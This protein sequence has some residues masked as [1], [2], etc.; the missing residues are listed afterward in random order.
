MDMNAALIER[1]RQ[2]THPQDWRFEPVDG[3][4]LLM[5]HPGAQAGDIHATDG[6][7]GYVLR[8]INGRAHEVWSSDDTLPNIAE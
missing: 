3:N 1:A 2:T 7:S 4:E 5:R 8:V 6:E